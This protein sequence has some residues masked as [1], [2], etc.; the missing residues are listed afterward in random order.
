MG[1]VISYILC[2]NTAKIR[3]TPKMYSCKKCN[4]KY[5]NNI[6]TCPHHKFRKNK[7][8]K[9]KCIHCELYKSKYGSSLCYHNAK[10]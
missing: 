3:K 7:N 2:L 5:L 6:R 9:F 8:G 1:N 10:K 4:L